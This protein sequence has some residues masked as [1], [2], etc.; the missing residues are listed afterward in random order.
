[1]IQAGNQRDAHAM[2]TRLIDFLKLRGVTALLTNLTSE[3]KP[4]R[5]R[6]WRFPPWW[7]AGY[8]CET[9]N[10]NGERNRALYVL[11]SR[12]MTHSN[13]LREFVLTPH[14]IDLLDV[15]VGPEEF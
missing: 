14:G 5:R 6:T 15:Y 9:S 11:K 3:G 7:T 13:Q 1:M 12:G 8:L 4:S 2:L 10:S